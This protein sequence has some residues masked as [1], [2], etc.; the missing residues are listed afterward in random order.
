METIIRGERVDI[1][2][3]RHEK[4]IQILDYIKAFEVMKKGVQ[5]SLNGFPGTLASER[6]YYIHKMEIYDKCIMRLNERYNKL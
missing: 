6:P 2:I 3:A 5:E 1:L 4:A